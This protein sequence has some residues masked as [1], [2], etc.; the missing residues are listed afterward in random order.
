MNE[1]HGSHWLWNSGHKTKN[2]RRAGFFGAQTLKCKCPEIDG[3]Y[4]HRQP[5]GKNIRKKWLKL[6]NLVMHV[7][8]VYS[9]CTSCAPTLPGKRRSVNYTVQPY[10]GAEDEKPNVL[11]SSGLTGSTPLNRP[12]HW[13]HCRFACACPPPWGLNLILTEIV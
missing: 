11:L 13:P 12:P 5:K 4:I 10:W 9:M 7:L 6:P 1:K 2:N 3:S 8:N